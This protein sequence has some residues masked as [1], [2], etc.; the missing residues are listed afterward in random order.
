MT[1]AAGIVAFVD[2][3]LSRRVMDEL[4]AD[5]YEP[6]LH[7]PRSH[8][9]MFEIAIPG[10]GFDVDDLRTMVKMSELTGASLGLDEHGWITLS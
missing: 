3:V 4:V 1:G 7:G 8:D 6:R 2:E 10:H 5:G 9:G